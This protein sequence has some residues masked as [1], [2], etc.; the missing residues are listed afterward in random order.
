VIKI[1]TNISKK[2]PIPGTEFSSQQFGASMEIEVSD[3]DTPENIQ[4]RIRDLYSLVTQAV[5][6]QISAATGNNGNGGQPPPVRRT[7]YGPPAPPQN[8]QTAQ[9]GSGYSGK[10]IA[11]AGGNGGNGGNGHRSGA[12][13]AQCRAIFA[14]CKSLNLDMNAELAN[15]NVTDASQLHVK[16]ASRLID[17]L[18]HRQAAGNPEPHY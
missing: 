1:S 17:D 16:D 18:K 3:A 8:R 6:E 11:R 2:V 14:I 13:E 12:T 7:N 4:V 5:D 9:A 15:Y 10:R